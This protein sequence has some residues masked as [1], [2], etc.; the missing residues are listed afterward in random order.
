MP[1]STI[2]G[3]LENFLARG[4]ECAYAQRAGYRFTRWSYKKT[5][6]FAFQ[7]A[8]ELEAR[9]IG[10]G[11]RVLLW[12]PNS[13]EWVAAFFG[14]ALRG[15][16]AVPMDDAAS[17]DF[18]YRVY[19][20]TNAKLA[21]CS[22]EHGK[23]LGPSAVLLL[24]Q[25]PE[26]LSQQS[27]EPYAAAALTPED[28]LEIIF[29]SGTTAEPKGVVIT[30]GNVLSNI[31]PLEAEIKKYLKY[32]RFVHPVRFLNL[33]P[34]SHVFGQFLGIFLPQLMGG[35]VFFTDTFKPSEI[36]GM[37]HR[38]RISVLVS[39]PRVLQS[40]KEKIQRDFEDSGEL[41]EFQRRFQR[42]EGKHFLHRW[43]IFRRIHRLFGWKFWAFISGGAALD[44]VTEQFWG[45]L[46]LAV[47][48]GYGLTETT[49]LISVN[50]PFKLGK[51]SIGKVLAGREVKLAPDGE[52]LVRGGGVASTVMKGSELHTAT[53][54]EGWFHTGDIG[55]LD[56]AGNL[57]FK[58]RKK[59]VIVTS[60]GMNVYPED[61]EAAMRKQPEVK[62]CVVI[63]F[64]DGGNAEPCAVLIL[65]DP[66]KDAAPIVQKANTLLAEYQ[67]AR[68][69]FVWPEE[70]FPRTSTQKPKRG[71]IAK[72]VLGGL[73]DVSHGALVSPLAELIGRISKH[74]A[75]N[76]SPDAN[77]DSD[78]NLSSLDRVELMSALED[79]YQV[80]LS[81]ANF[82]AV[83][84][85]GDLER[86]LRGGTASMPRAHYH[87]PA[88][89]QR[90][91]TTWLRL[92]AH[93]LL[94]RPAMLALGWPKVEGRA[95]LKNVQ[96]P[97][98]VICNHIDDVDVGFVQTALPARFGHKLA[99][100][101]GGEALEILRTPPPEQNIFRKIFSGIEW[102]LGVALLNIFPLPRA[103][104]FRESF[105]YAGESVDRG[106]SVL[107][108]PEGHH[109]TD[110]K[111]R[112]FQAGIG[113][114]AKSLA[115]PVVPMRIDGLFEVKK[116]G[117]RFA[118]PYQIRVKIGAPIRID[119][120]MEPQEI[121]LLLQRHV[122]NI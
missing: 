118:K 103:A 56:E 33:L 109:T 12:G 75:G 2:T 59:E 17:V 95:F 38:E 86:V 41:P 105:A 16:V 37:I 76:V 34:L 89:A 50:H 120:E 71:E 46:G 23:A 115:I 73:D 111:L 24:E 58:G 9:G 11:D 72:A 20:Q 70:D 61:L 66:A 22:L 55:E 47:I 84:T 6:D 43:W 97:V 36:L 48:Q 5:A 42:A 30:H 91:P 44:S 62:D 99:T 29:T 21:V 85:V 31:A 112:P 90:W 49:S 94:M 3:F 116:R 83:N 98:L 28:P 114:L 74:G 102:T 40:L 52:I 1:Q 82:S 92:L 108:F 93:Y 69:W 54:D 32:E 64:E 122:E 19:T 15:T 107:V 14:C 87:Y 18:A 106:Y 13:A 65:R 39:V 79:R 101:A 35:T 60:A 45:R 81:E 121:A 119:R 96:G 63:P 57:Y 67:R 104:G 78:L 7:F 113:I 68:K 25:L 8:R 4:A 117:K 27:T 77:L 88:W 80:D 100:A 110:G 51:G 10:K 53:G 26:I